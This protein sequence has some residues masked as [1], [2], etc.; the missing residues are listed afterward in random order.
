MYSVYENLITFFYYSVTRDDLILGFMAEY[1]RRNKIE[2]GAFEAALLICGRGG[3]YKLS[4]EVKDMIVGE[5]APVMVVEYSTHQAMQKIHA[6][7][8]KFNIDDRH[9]V[10]TAVEHYEP[11]IDF[12]ELL[13]R[14]KA[15]DSSFNEPGTVSF[16]DLKKL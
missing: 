9:R 16:S 10:N 13:R 7:T 3:K 11:Y 1:Q 12:D 6:Y 8:P 4:Q 14:T 15:S 2:D 5:S